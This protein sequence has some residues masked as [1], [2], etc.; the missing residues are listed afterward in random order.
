MRGSLR[1]ASLIFG[2]AGYSHAEPTGDREETHHGE[3]TRP[4]RSR[5]RRPANAP[6][7]GPIRRPGAAVLAFR[8]PLAQLADDRAG[9]TVALE[10]AEQLVFAAGALSSLGPLCC[11]YS[12][13]CV[14]YECSEVSIAPARCR[15]SSSGETLS[16]KPPLGLYLPCR[17][18]LT[19]NASTSRHSAS[20]SLGAL[21]ISK[22]LKRLL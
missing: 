16:Q 11:P 5:R 21:P 18:L 4:R 8:E 14:E 6:V 7:A 2:R 10:P 9:H 20:N 1:G 15:T 19:N 13:E 17:C 3:D 22:V 12:P